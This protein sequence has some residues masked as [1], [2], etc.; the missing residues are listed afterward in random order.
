MKVN[1]DELADIIVEI[2]DGV[3]VLESSFGPIYVKHFHQLDTRKVLSKRK[4]Y[5]NEAKSRGLMSEEE[6]LKKLIDDE[7][8][9][10]ESEKEIQ[11]KSDS[12]I[13]DG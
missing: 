4:I 9:S 5:I 2:F 3:T 8:W 7:M 11:D 13:D 6:A 1:N 12:E 10:E